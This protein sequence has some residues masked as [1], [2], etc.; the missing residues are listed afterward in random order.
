ME[1][2][3]AGFTLVEVMVSAAIGVVIVALL[4]LTLNRM[5]F[6]AA[7]AEAK[8]RSL[9]SADHVAERMVAEASSAW[10]VYVPANGDGHEI[11]FFA[12]DGSHNTYNW[13]Y[14]YDAPTKTLARYVLVAGSAP[15]LDETMGTFDAFSAQSVDASQLG[16]VDPLFASSSVPSVTFGYDAAPGATGGNGYVKVSLQANGV[17]RSELLASSTAPTTFTVVVTYTPSPGPVPT[18]TPTPMT[19]TTP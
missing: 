19:M 3:E 7:S 18:A 10:A 13:A 16:T 15:K 4:A 5:V 6:S 17:N 1:E 9:S 14:S 8:V 12:Q 2:R 11:D